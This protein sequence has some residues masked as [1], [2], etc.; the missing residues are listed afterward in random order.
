MTRAAF[1]HPPTFWGLEQAGWWMTGRS[2]HAP[3]HSC[4]TGR[5]GVCAPTRLAGPSLPKPLKSTCRLQPAHSAHHSFPLPSDPCHFFSPGTLSWTQEGAA[6][7]GSPGPRGR[8]PR[9]RG[10]G[11]WTGEASPAEGP[12]EP[13]GQALGAISGAERAEE[14]PW[15]FLTLPEP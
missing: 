10:G 15:T 5:G 14:R 13:R 4:P 6:W 11:D 2:A 12:L 8:A 9:H 7:R 3:I 1:P